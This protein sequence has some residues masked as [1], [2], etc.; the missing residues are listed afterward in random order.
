MGLCTSVFV[1]HTVPDGA[2][3]E[4]AQWCGHFPMES[5]CVCAVLSGA[6]IMGRGVWISLVL[7]NLPLYS[8]PHG[9]EGWGQTSFLFI[10]CP[11]HSSLIV[12]SCHTFP[13]EATFDRCQTQ[14]KGWIGFSVLS[15]I[16]LSHWHATAPLPYLNHSC[17]GWAPACIPKQLLTT[18][19][20]KM[21]Q[22][23]GALPSQSNLFQLPTLMF[24]V[25][26]ELLKF[27]CHSKAIC[28]SH[29]G[30][31]SDS[32]FTRLVLIRKDPL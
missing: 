13:W 6:N 14:S 31:C 12:A 18:L 30:L 29:R 20:Q 23:V 10:H 25:K 16:W 27:D 28:I 4:A 17:P 1:K 22:T 15:L 8:E 26:H 11:H 32:L 24:S 5:H 21:L 19:N 7:E 9:W 2:M 3:G